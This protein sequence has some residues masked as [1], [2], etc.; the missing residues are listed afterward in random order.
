[1]KAAIR[2]VGLILLS[3]FLASGQNTVAPTDDAVRESVRREAAKIA[4]RERLAQAQAAHKRGE[5]SAAAKLY[6]D[7]LALADK[8]ST[9]V[10]LELRDVTRG[11][12]AVRLAL[13]EQAIRRAD[14]AD[15][16]THVNRILRLDPR[17][18]A[19]L[20]MRDKNNVEKRRAAGMRPSQETLSKIPDIQ[21]EKLTAAT[22]VQDAKFL[23]EAGK[24]NEAEAKLRQAVKIDPDN[25][26]AFYYLNIIK[27]ARFK[28][29]S[30]FQRALSKQ[31][32]LDI[33]KAWNDPIK[34]D[35]LPSPN[36]YARTNIVH[37]SK[38][39]QAIYSKLD[40][41]RLDFQSDGLL[42]GQVIN[43][44]SDEA[45]KRDP[46][47]RGINIM[48]NSAL[49]V[50]AA[51]PP[52][53]DPAT[54]LPIPGTAPEAVDLSTVVVRLM[55]PLTDITLGQA[56]DAITKAADRPIKYSVEDY[57]IVV[58]Q[59]TPEPVQLQT[60]WFRVDP[61]TFI[62]GLQGVTAF[63]F[64]G[65]TGQG[66][67]GQGGGGG[68][69]GGRGGRG[70]GGGGGGFGGGGGGQG[71][72]Q[73]QSGG[74]TYV[75][76]QMARFGGGGVQGGTGGGNA[77]T[78]NRLP[79]TSADKS[80]SIPPT[81][82]DNLT[83][84]TPQEQYNNLVRTYFQAAGVDLAAPKQLFFNDRLGQLMVRATLQDLDIIEQAVQVLNMSPP[85][86]LLEAKFAE[87]SQDDT[88]AMGFDWL[89]GNTTIG[90][91]KI[92]V[93]PGTAPSFIGRPSF[94]NPSGVFPGPWGVDPITG[95]F[96][97]FSPGNVPPSATDNV[98][99]SGLRQSAPAVATIS[100]ILTDPQFRVVIRALEQRQGVD[101]LSAP[102]VM[103]VSSRQAQI[104]VVDVRYIVTDLD[105]DQT[106]TGGGA[107]GV[108]GVQ[109]GGGAVGSLIQ[110]IAEPF[111]LGPVLDVVPYVSADG[112][113]IQMTIIPTIKEFIGYDLENARLFSSQV[114]SVAGGGTAGSALTQITPLPIFR[115]RQVVTSASVWDGQ[116]IV[117]GGLISEN[118]TKTKDKVPLLGDLPIA[119]KL[120]RSESSLTRKKNL[121][122]FVTPTII[123]PAGNRV[124]AD[125]ELPFAQ[126][127]IPPQ[128]T[129]PPTA[130]PAP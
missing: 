49:D 99:T 62:Q 119:G 47:K 58:S 103:T 52:A 86:I 108:G 45:R 127:G 1:M 48:V 106:A 128:P 22:L 91:G 72:D 50:P 102:K 24:L 101:L 109:T 95:Q 46:E 2:T 33:S 13:A 98:L 28:Q 115:L 53:I 97:P 16:D 88:R 89:V 67:G 90:G 25:R 70:G 11:I 64:G 6:E 7:C 78:G 92:G 54:G 75:G 10:D 129:T 96:V 87:V 112:Y 14:F 125:E 65:V 5:L 122:I 76:V 27:E 3:T 111:E 30:E 60:R 83:I 37:T 130:P 55:P 81:G 93:Q 56:L 123:D 107:A 39:R 32:L 19:A 114:Q 4:L 63:D 66:G 59:R 21:A 20:A 116:T 118:V 38:G 15:A 126:S 42:L 36:M 69:G 121:L 18:E 117:L 124:H 80:Y 44:L 71:G 31:M 35:A 120:F 29:E 84:V 104:K 17:N 79:G 8:I 113:T 40:R 77:T 61:N 34:R 105:V 100:G 110:A 12:I 51:P 57:A 74:S 26:A 94:S 41:I 73:G 23:Y 43:L 85:Q 82:I 9:G 68:G